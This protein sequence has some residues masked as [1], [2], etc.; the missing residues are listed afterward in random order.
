MER[1]QHNCKCVGMSPDTLQN[2][3]AAAAGFRSPI[4][5]EE[6]YR[7]LVANIPDDIWVADSEGHCVFSSNVE[8]L[9]GY[10]PGEIYESGV[11]Y[12]RIHPED[13]PMVRQAYERLHETG[14]LFTVDYRLKR[15]DGQWIWLHA[16]AMSTYE[17]DGKRYT[18][19]IASDIT[20]RKL[21]EERLRASVER[22]R[23][24]FQ[25]NLAGV[26]P[27]SGMQSGVHPSLRLHR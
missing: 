14:A 25:R 16:K 18:I 9:T 6:M 7:L 10:S 12:E 17:K 2:K 24:L 13:A 20:A 19:G 3:D 22:Y 5:S 8:R 15:K 4:Q 26:L 1:W 27:H 11:W 21:V 23:L